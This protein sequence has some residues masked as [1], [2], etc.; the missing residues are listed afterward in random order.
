MSDSSSSI[1]LDAIVEEF[2]EWC[3][4][5]RRSS[6]EKNAKRYPQF[7]EEILIPSPSPPR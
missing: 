1:D 7:A 4:S 6:V 5:G 3:R 2:T